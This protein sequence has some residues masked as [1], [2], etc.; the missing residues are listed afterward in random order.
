MTYCRGSGAVRG[1][2]VDNLPLVVKVL[3]WVIAIG[4]AAVLVVW[5]TA[6][7]F[8]LSKARGFWK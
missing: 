4:I 8:A 5:L 7:V 2:G 6:A 3:L 1:R